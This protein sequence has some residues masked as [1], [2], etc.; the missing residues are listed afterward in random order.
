[1]RSKILLT[2]LFPLLASAQYTVSQ[3]DSLCDVAWDDTIGADLVNVVS[4]H[5]Q[6]DHYYFLY[7]ITPPLNRFQATGELKYLED[8]VYAFREAMDGAL[9]SNTFPASTNTGATAYTSVEPTSNP[10]Y[11]NDSYLSW[12]NHGLREFTQGYT[13]GGEYSLYD[14]HGMNDI[15]RL[16]W[17]LK[18]FPALR[19]T[20]NNRAGH[21]FP[22]L[23]TTT[24]SGTYQDD[25]DDILAF[26][27]AN[28]WDK[29]TTRG[30]PHG[31]TTY[32]ASHWANLAYWLY[33]C[34]NDPE[35]KTE[36]DAW[37]TDMTSSSLPASR[38]EPSSMREQLRVYNYPGVGTGYIWN[39]N[40]GTFTG[41]V[42]V[43]HANAEARVICNTYTDGY[44]WDE[45]DKVRF[46]NTSDW[47]ISQDPNVPDLLSGTGSVDNSYSIGWACWGRFDPALQ[48]K[49]EQSATA[50][51][52]VS[53]GRRW[54]LFGQLIYNR[55]YLNGT[56]V[57]PDYID[58]AELPAF[59]AKKK[60]ATTILI[61]N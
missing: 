9:A 20:S 53:T 13:N 21:N 24:P 55:A 26:V 59:N 18:K 33:K 38:A 58:P 49:Y 4:Y 23:R 39:A 37:L 8:A 2:F 42:D 14:K 60:S 50:S 34:T 56:M 19:A 12:D 36:V 27:E 7:L 5:H 17:V 1:M 15:G 32:I 52:S 30:R 28:I 25:Y 29:W 45:T 41:S 11:Y 6:G 51:G 43:D 48:L 47:V 46:V 3:L 40:W 10:D 57:Y 61:S 44:Y 16:L 31:P 35:Y 54:M 22:G